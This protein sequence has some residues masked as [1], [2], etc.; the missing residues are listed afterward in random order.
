MIADSPQ[1]GADTSRGPSMMRRS[2]FFS[3]GLLEFAV[4]ALVAYFGFQLPSGQD[5]SQSFEQAQRVTNHAGTQVGLLQK[6][7]QGL[8]SARLENLSD[9]LRAE[10][11]AVTNTLRAQAVDFATV[12]TIRDALGGV[13]NGLD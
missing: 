2:L 10:T 6:Q 8:R 4:A 12:I 7:V 11:R 1:H 3:F 5:I 13:S 9:R